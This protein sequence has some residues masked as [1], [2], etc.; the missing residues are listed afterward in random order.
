LVLACAVIEIPLQ[1]FTTYKFYVR[2]CYSLL[3]SYKRNECTVL[4]RKP[5]RKRPVGRPDRRE[6]NIKVGL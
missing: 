1:I 5:E 3:S 6:N 4:V 2:F